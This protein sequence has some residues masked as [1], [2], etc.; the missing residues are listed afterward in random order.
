MKL[1]INLALFFVL[2]G[3]AFA[4]NKIEFHANDESDMAYINEGMHQVDS[5]PEDD[6]EKS[7][8][9]SDCHHY[10]VHCS[11]LC[12][13]LLLFN[14]VLLLVKDFSISLYRPPIPGLFKV[15]PIR[16]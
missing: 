3:S 8:T 9:A 6:S 16:S 5:I 14:Q 13:G 1:F 15:D 11:S 4:E 10:H 7:E 2:L 12:L